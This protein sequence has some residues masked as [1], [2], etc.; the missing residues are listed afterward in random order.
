MTTNAYSTD[1]QTLRPDDTVGHAIATVL[2]HR[3]LDL[4]VVDSKGHLIG[5][6]K[7]DRLLAGLLPKAAML[8]DALPD[9]SFVSDTVE[10]LGEKLTAL[11]P[12]KVR[13]VMEQP[14]PVVHPD[15]HIVEM[16]LLLQ[17]G[18]NA[19]PVVERKDRRLVGMVSTRDILTALRA[20]G[21]R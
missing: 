6:L 20:A 4:P 9:L 13:D 11:E 1:Y 2:E 8:G 21:G 16:V 12:K 14:E 10:Q 17:R 5:I 3:V 19:L 15:T 7:V 18:A